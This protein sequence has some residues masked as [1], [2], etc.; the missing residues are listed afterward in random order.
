MNS[1]DTANEHTNCF[2]FY[3]LSPSLHQCTLEYSD[4]IKLL[5]DICLKSFIFVGVCNLLDLV[6]QTVSNSSLKICIKLRQMGHIFWLAFG[7]F[8]FSIL[9]APSTF[10]TN[11]KK[12]YDGDHLF[13]IVVKDQ[14]QLSI[15][16]NAV[17][18]HPSN[19][20]YWRRSLAQNQQV[21]DVQV[22]KTTVKW[23]QRY[24]IESEISFSIID[25][26]IQK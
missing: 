4:S 14:E 8:I 13:R 24:L 5:P 6:F 9:L 10:A 19:F 2:S 23:F 16:D 20:S 3:R 26:D 1:A 18:K 7:S 15:I 12:R 25:D 21:V 22:K 11:Q 17:H